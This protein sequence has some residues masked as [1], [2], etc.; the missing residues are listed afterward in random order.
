MSKT[1]EP[2]EIDAYLHKQTPD[3]YLISLDED[4]DEAVWVPKSLAKIVEDGDDDVY[5]FS[6]PEW[7]A[8]DKGLI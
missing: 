3:A 5:V 2:V 6:M 8:L 7:L 4:E 1:S